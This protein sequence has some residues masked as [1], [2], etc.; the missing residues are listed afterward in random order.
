MKTESLQ[1]STLGQLHKH[2]FELFPIKR[3][4]VVLHQI[5]E[6]DRRLVAESKLR[7][8]NSSEDTSEDPDQMRLS[9]VVSTANIAEMA[10]GDWALIAPF[11]DHASPGGDYSQHFDRAQSDKVVATWNSITGIAARVFKN[12]VHGFGARKSLPVFDGHPETDKRRWPVAKLLAQVTDLRTGNE[13]LEGRIKKEASFDA[14]RGRGPL[15]P[16]PLWWHWPPAGTPPTVYPEMLE[17]IGLVP[18]PNIAGVPAWTTNASLSPADRTGLVEPGAPARE[19][20]DTNT[21]ANIMD[22]KKLIELLGLS[23]DAT[24]EQIEAA[25]ATANSARAEL[26]TANAATQQAN[27]A[28]QT[29]NTALASAE[30]K[31]SELATANAGLTTENAT[32]KSANS[33]LIKGALD[34]AEKKGAITPAERAG[35]EQKITANAAETLSELAGRKAMNTQAIEIAGNRID[36]STANSRAD[37]LETAIAKRMK[38]ESLNRSDAYARCQADPTL[39]PLFDAMKDPTRRS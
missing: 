39:A 17:S 21:T 19:D 38:D 1:P 29:A 9:A 15:Y 14:A 25:L 36:L 20:A 23:A 27:T 37:A 34:L 2:G 26:V 6:R 22:K 24:D 11:G 32:L 16:S 31:V 8:A 7:T 30:K 35:F 5:I 12:I 28:L 18:T 3:I 4:V 10:D 13:G 33:A